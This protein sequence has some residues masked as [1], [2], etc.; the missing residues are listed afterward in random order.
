MLP[1][2]NPATQFIPPHTIELTACALTPNPVTELQVIPSD[3]A[4]VL[5]VELDAINCG[6][7]LPFANKVPPATY[8]FPAIPAPPDTTSAPVAA[9]VDAVFVVIIL[10]PI[11]L[12]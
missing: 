3:D 6:L 2:A 10:V 12:I 8:V 7:Y 4:M 9:L 11:P 1:L 5:G